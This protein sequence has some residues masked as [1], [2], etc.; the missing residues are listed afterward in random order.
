MP[1]IDKIIQN[2]LF[3]LQTDEDMKELFPTKSIITIY[4][5]EKKLNEILSLSVFHLN[6]T[7]PKVQS[8]IVINVIFSRIILHLITNL[9]ARLMV[10]RTVIEVA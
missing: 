2:I 8:V 6:L 4:R 5:R 10:E 9:S 3:I 7:K 1:N